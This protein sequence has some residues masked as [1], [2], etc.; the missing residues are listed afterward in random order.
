MKNRLILL[1]LLFST[2]AIAQPVNNDCIDAIFIPNVNNWCSANAQYTNVGATVSLPAPPSC[3]IGNNND[4]W[5]NFTAVASNL[6]VSIVGNAA[7]FPGGTLNNPEVAIFSG[8][9][10]SLTE[11]ACR[12][13]ALGTDVVDQ[14]A[15]GL[16]IGDTY[17]ILVDGRINNTGD[18]KLCINSFNPVPE[19]S[20][21]C[22]TGVV[23]CDKS[24]FSVANI[25]GNGFDP[26][27]IDGSPC[28]SSACGYGEFNSVWYKW[29][30][31]QP[32]TLTFTV[33]PLNPADDIDF[34]V[35]EIPSLNNCGNKTSLRC[36]T[37]GENVGSPLP[38]WVA[39]TGATGLRAGDGDDHENCGCAA[40][41]NNFLAPIQ[42]VSGRSYALVIENFSGVGSTANNG[43]SISFGGTGTFL[44]PEAEF[45]TNPP[46]IQGFPDT[47][48]WNDI[49]FTDQSTQGVSPLV[50]WEWDFGADA[51]P[52][53]ANTQ[54]PHTVSYSTPGI[55]TIILTIESQSGCLTTEVTTIY[56]DPCCGDGGSGAW[57][58]GATGVTADVTCPF[59]SDGSITTTISGSHPPIDIVWNNGEVTPNIGG[60]G[61][62]TYSYTLTDAY[63]CEAFGDF[64]IISPGEP[65][66]DIVV[67]KPTCNGGTDGAV[68]ANV[69][70]PEPPYLFNWDGTGF[71]TSNTITN[72]PI[73]VHT[74]VIQD[75]TG[76][77]FNFTIDVNELVLELDPSVQV[78]VDPSCFGSSDGSITI[79]LSNGLAP[80][81][82][83]FN[84][85]AGWVTSNTLLNLPEGTYSVQARDA[86]GCLG[87]FSPIILDDPDPLGITTTSMDV[88]CFGDTDG[89]ITT[90]VT[91]GTPAYNYNW[92]NGAST[93]DV[94]NL[95]PG[96]YEVTVTDANGCVIT[97]ADFIDEPD[98]V[99]ITGVDA[100]D[101][102]CFGGSGGGLTV[103]AIGGN[104]PY[105]YSI[106][107]IN[108]Q[109][110]SVFTGLPAGTYTVIVRDIF[111]CEFTETAT[112]T[113]PYQILVD[114]RWDTIIDLGNSVGIQAIINSTDAHTYSWTPSST[115]SC[116][117]CFEPEA[118][119]VITTTYTVT[120]E[121][122]LGC[123]ATDTVT[124]IV[125][126]VRPVYIPNAFT[127][128]LDGINDAFVVYG[129]PAVGNVRQ[130]DV[131]D[132]WG[133]Q[134]FSA[135]NIPPNEDQFGW[136][137]TFRG[138][139]MNPGV[140]VYLVE[141]EFLD[142]VVEQYSG[143]ITLIQ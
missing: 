84:N 98:P 120:V 123:I 122:F 55:K 114:A 96:N 105:E 135:S 126:P 48:C 95:P 138:S 132:R 94:S 97:A 4:V 29:T 20:S 12:S 3:F 143:S 108:Y 50:G 39:C 70:G 128:N 93:S 5:F 57:A 76:C 10:G 32:G 54:G 116:D 82:Y 75:N 44:G 125:N 141:V 77:E 117:D 16:N 37:S 140:F 65:I 35:Y 103:F 90:V 67:T 102:V 78:L 109:I 41:D 53:S 79:A 91:G 58:L 113:E 21:D 121:T 101:N 28:S 127:P 27:E 71:G 136:D 112:I 142:G 13:D 63:D 14:F 1:F 92:S 36:M 106:D 62:G 59:A 129:G 130:M 104:S 88:S 61:P 49:V 30:C 45:T 56:V 33:T 80:Y 11:I 73:S 42:M 15:T 64:L 2:I 6:N 118:M 139:T 81:E 7:N 87:D 83:N 24:S 99:T 119:P 17:Y 60:L 38:D 133:E 72:L 40:G 69:T 9:C 66:I 34:W 22:S 86:N 89:V 25:S 107:G 52:G 31:D 51:S 26:N 100:I 46:L 110:D 137:G 19:P 85:G 74:L 115:L 18:F 111:G 43:I 131:Y 134:V 124:V 8:T 23:L 68:V 47:V